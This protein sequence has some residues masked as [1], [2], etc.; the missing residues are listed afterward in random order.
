M[1]TDTMNR[2]KTGTYFPEKYRGKRII[3][4]CGECAKPFR[5][6][7]F[8]DLMN[9]WDYRPME[10]DAHIMNRYDLNSHMPVRSDIKLST[11]HSELAKVAAAARAFDARTPLFDFAGYGEELDCPCQLIRKLARG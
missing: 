3:L 11:F 7:W 5:T 9:P 10:I 2:L 4:V 1:I 6:A 8:E